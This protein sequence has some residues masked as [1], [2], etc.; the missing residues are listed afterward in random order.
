M[1][2][3]FSASPKPKRLDHESISAFEQGGAGH[4]TRKRGNP[5]THNPANEGSEPLSRLSVDLPS[6]THR[7]FKALCSGAGLKMANEITAF[8]ERRISELE[9]Q[10]TH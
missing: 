6:S 8:I 7:R 9:N 3:S 10:S 4:D 1:S 2:K 5:L